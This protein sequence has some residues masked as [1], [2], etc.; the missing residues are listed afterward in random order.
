VR[1]HRAPPLPETTACA[2]D[3]TAGDDLLERLA[4]LYAVE[5]SQPAISQTK[6]DGLLAH[7]GM[8][9]E[10]PA[11]AYFRVTPIATTSTPPSRGR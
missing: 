1:R 11:T 6:L 10:G 2:E 7:Y 5:A 8:Q 3:W 9:A 4:V